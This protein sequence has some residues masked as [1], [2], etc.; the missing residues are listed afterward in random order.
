MNLLSLI[1]QCLENNSQIQTKCY[2]RES[3]LC[4]IYLRKLCPTKYPHGVHMCIHMLIYAPQGAGFVYSSQILLSDPA[5][6][7][8]D[9]RARASSSTS[10]MRGPSIGCASPV[11]SWIC[12]VG[13]LLRTDCLMDPARPIVESA[14]PQ[15]HNMLGLALAWL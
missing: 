8:H 10:S 1:N 12:T 3:S 4:K 15:P 2:S 7:L 11:R 6:M 9:T 5:C 13:S 14:Y